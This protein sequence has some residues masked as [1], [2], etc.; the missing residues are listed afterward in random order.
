M[1][2]SA[3]D[4]VTEAPDCPFPEDFFHQLP[5]G[6]V[7][8]VDG[9]GVSGGAFAQPKSTFFKYS[10]SLYGFDHVDDGLILLI[11]RQVKAAGRSLQTIDYFFPGKQLQ[12]FP[13]GVLAGVDSGGYFF[14]AG[15]FAL[16]AFA[17]Q[18]ND[19]FNGVFA[20]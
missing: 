13:D 19:G 6:A 20:G 17:R 3:G 5:G 9:A 14:D 11:F 12:Y 2:Q 18:I 1:G 15:F 16:I 7:F 8:V 10:V 4:R